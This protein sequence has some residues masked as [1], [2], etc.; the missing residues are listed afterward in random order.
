SAETGR[1]RILL[2]DVAVV[3]TLNRI[4]FGWANYF[5]LGPVSKAYRAVGTT[6]PQ[7]ASSVA[8]CQTQTVVARDQAVSGLGIARWVGLG[9]PHAADAQLPVD[10][11][12]NLSPR[13]G[14][15][16]TARPVR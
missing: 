1:N 9:V 14:C 16:K 12:V 6:R 4:M 2:D 13:A 11:I 7:E 10:E 3:A 5:C 8:V 15:G